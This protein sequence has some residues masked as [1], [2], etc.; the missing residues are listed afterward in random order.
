MKFDEF[1]GFNVIDSCFDEIEVIWAW[2]R[3]SSWP[4]PQNLELV[5]ERRVCSLSELVARSSP[6][7]LKCTDLR[8]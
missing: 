5:A 2:P 6:V 3:P 1:L 4:E 7:T 8:R